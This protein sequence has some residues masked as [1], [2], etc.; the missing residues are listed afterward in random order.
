M[1]EHDNGWEFAKRLS[2]ALLKIRPLGG[3]ELFVRRN[4][5]HYA[6]PAYCGAA[7]EAD[8]KRRHEVMSDNVR[9]RGR[10]AALEM[11]IGEE[12]IAWNCQDAANQMLVDEIC[13][14][15]TIPPAD[16]GSVREG[17]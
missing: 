16:V 13:E 6:D 2:D 12:M 5:Q 9:L 10:V 14:R 4:G 3:S 17:S 1:S 15:S 11:I 8:A 7:I